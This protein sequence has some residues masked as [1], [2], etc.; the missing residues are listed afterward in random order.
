MTKL[1]YENYFQD[2]KCKPHHSSKVH[3]LILRHCSYIAKTRTFTFDSK[4][5]VESTPIPSIHDQTDSSSVTESSD[6]LTSISSMGS[7]AIYS[8]TDETVELHRQSSGFSSLLDNTEV[9]TALTSFEKTPSEEWSPN[10]DASTNEL[11]PTGQQTDI[12]KL[13]S[14]GTLTSEW[15]LTCEKSPLTN[16]QT[17][18]IEETP[19]HEGAHTSKR[20]PTSQEYSTGQTSASDKWCATTPTSEETPTIKERSS[21]EEP[22]SEIVM[23]DDTPTPRAVLQS[24]KDIS[25]DTFELLMLMLTVLENLCC[26][27]ASSYD[28]TLTI[29][30]SGQLIDLIDNMHDKKGDDGD[31]DHEDF[32]VLWDLVAS[33]IARLSILRTVLFFLFA[34]FRNPK[35]AKQ[36]VRNNY[37]SKLVGFVD[38][39]LPSA[40]LTSEQLSELV[41]SVSSERSSSLWKTFSHIVYISLAFRG[42]LTFQTS[43]LQFGSLINST[44]LA[45]SR[46]LL[47]QFSLA[48]GFDYLATI[49]LKCEEMHLPGSHS[50]SK[51]TSLASAVKM[52][53]R[54]TTLHVL[55]LAGKIISLLKKSKL[56]CKAEADVVPRRKSV[57]SYL[58]FQPPSELMTSDVDESSESAGDM[59]SENDKQSRNL[60]KLIVCLHNVVFCGTFGRL[61]AKFVE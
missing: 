24:S 4:N 56:N 38:H 55:S 19:S 36:L 48:D 42:L 21:G 60:G 3:E 8:S 5:I 2:S 28:T 35:S 45:L 32:E 59:E 23:N 33:I 43:C 14:E 37:V 53:P 16:E 18:I 17:P 22:T 10:Y 58:Q 13:L 46:E 15:T 39:E 49:A 1:D 61:T 9:S 44:L 6:M 29:K 20:T 30:T 34:T 26:R 52:L 51:M 31:G 47:E 11:T 25:I 27:E 40:L 54:D 57:D 12:G 41:S 50:D 7:A